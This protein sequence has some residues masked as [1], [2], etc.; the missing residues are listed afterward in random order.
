MSNGK[1]FLVW[2]LFFFTGKLRKVF[3][4]K[5]FTVFDSTVVWLQWFLFFQVIHSRVLDFWVTSWN[6][7]QD[8]FN[9]K[10]QA[11]ITGNQI[12]FPLM[13][14]KTCLLDWI[15]EGSIAEANWNIINMGF[16]MCSSLFWMKQNKQQLV[17][18]LY[19]RTYSRAKES[20]AF[21]LPDCLTPLVSLVLNSPQRAHCCPWKVML[22][23]SYYCLQSPTSNHPQPRS[24]SIPLHPSPWSIALGSSLASRISPSAKSFPGWKV[25]LPT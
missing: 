16:K 3:L 15:L 24:L 11:L 13:Y 9:Q 6:K 12:E 18:S 4:L 5:S 19:R 2:L 1:Y 17:A 14:N 21:F 10:P 8:H 7:I 20:R 22:F 25:T 23:M